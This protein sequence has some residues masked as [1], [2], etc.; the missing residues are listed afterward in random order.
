MSSNELLQIF[1]DRLRLLRKSRDL[2][3][4]ELADKS[5]VDQSRI[6]RIESGNLNP[7]LQTLDALSRGL[8][9]ELPR[10]LDLR[11]RI[12]TALENR[13]ARIAMFREK[14][15]Q[16]ARIIQEKLP[17]EE[18]EATFE[19]KFRPDSRDMKEDDV[20]YE[21]ISPEGGFSTNDSNLTNNDK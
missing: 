16:L 11:G 13:K 21:G 3:Q 15:Q 17:D 18:L 9:L 7:T 12:E 8:D 19:V 5:G 20:E 4:S 6:S 10:L 14:N 1:G 2:A